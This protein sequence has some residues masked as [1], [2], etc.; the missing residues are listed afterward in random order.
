[1][2]CNCN[3]YLFLFEFCLNQQA[4]DEHLFGTQI[5]Y[6]LVG[7]KLDASNTGCCKLGAVDSVRLNAR[8][9]GF[10]AWETFGRPRFFDV[11]RRRPTAWRASNV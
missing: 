7:N 9:N 4:R 3:T 2:K 1:M 10:D 8:K 6:Y 11:R 5:S